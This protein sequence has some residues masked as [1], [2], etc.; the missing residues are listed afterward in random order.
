MNVS[1]AESYTEA[2]SLWSR[3]VFRDV[4]FTARSSPLITTDLSYAEVITPVSFL[5]PR[6]PLTD[7]HSICV[8]PRRRSRL[9]KEMKYLTTYV[10]DDNFHVLGQVAS[11]SAKQLICLRFTSVVLAWAAFREQLIHKS[12]FGYLEYLLGSDFPGNYTFGDIFCPLAQVTVLR[13]L[14]SE[15]WHARRIDFGMK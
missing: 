6:V 13:L 9:R 10:Q 3:G 15:F 1:R 4:E 8:V 2:R 14:R 12:H 7:F 5:I 11:N